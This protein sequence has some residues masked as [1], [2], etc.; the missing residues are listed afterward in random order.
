MPSIRPET[1]ADYAAVDR[2]IRAAF[3]ARFGSES[4]AGL[5]AALRQTARPYI[6]LVAEKE[7]AIIGHIFFSPVTVASANETFTAM[8]LA[9]MAVAPASQKQ[10]VGSR[11][12]RAGLAACGRMGY[13]LVFVLGHADYYPRLGFVTAE[14]KGFAC[15]YAV[16]AD[17][18]MVAE[19]QP[20][21]A[22]GKSGLVRYMPEF[23]EL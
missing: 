4:E 14:T 17:H 3:L 15:E 10:G 13:Q 19:L 20:G 9:P 5:V 16:P 1:E 11:L 23:N 2:V 18:F 12:V 7:G 6:S 22:A 8:G 21:A